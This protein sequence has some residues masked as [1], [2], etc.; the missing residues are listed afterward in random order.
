MSAL[1]TPVPGI[2]AR[3]SRLSKGRSGIEADSESYSGRLL[4]RLPSLVQDRQP[5]STIQI[6]SPFYSRTP[7]RKERLT[8][9][10]KKPCHCTLKARKP[11]GIKAIRLEPLS[12]CSPHSATLG[13]QPIKLRHGSFSRDYSRRGVIHTE[14]SE[15]STQA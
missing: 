8:C 9:T 4:K 2:F 14:R 10:M 6:A 13:P 11:S 3:Q 7:G 5:L 12:Y 1:F 15:A